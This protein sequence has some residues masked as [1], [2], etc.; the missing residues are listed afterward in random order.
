MECHDFDL[1]Q[2]C[3]SLESLP[4][5]VDDVHNHETHTFL[6]IAT[7]QA[8]TNEMEE[9]VMVL[10]V[11]DAMELLLLDYDSISAQGMK[12]VDIYLC[13]INLDSYISLL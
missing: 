9:G 10:K 1:C 3:C 2:S 7:P 8:S 6:K 4:G 13:T 5:V 11:L 12:V